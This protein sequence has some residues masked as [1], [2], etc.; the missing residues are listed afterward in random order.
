[1]AM[2]E[3]TTEVSEDVQEDKPTATA[4]PAGKVPGKYSDKA[5]RG[6]LDKR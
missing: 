5:T 1:M 6:T 4:E 2:A 3:E